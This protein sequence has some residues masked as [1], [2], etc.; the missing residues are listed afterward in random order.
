MA[1]QGNTA[2]ATPD[3]G[4]I[5][6]AQLYIDSLTE[7]KKE[8]QLKLDEANAGY[9][10]AVGEYEQAK[11]RKDL[12][13]NYLENI[14]D[15]HESAA[16]VHRDLEIMKAQAQKVCTNIECLRDALY[17]YVSDVRIA[18][19]KLEELR[20]MLRHLM[21]RIACL[22]DPDLTPETSIMKC[23]ND[24]KAKIDEA[25]AAVLDSIYPVL[26]IVRAN[27]ELLR[28]ICNDQGGNYGLLFVLDQDIE[29]L[30]DAVRCGP[31]I[32]DG[33]TPNT[34]EPVGDCE[35]TQE[36]PNC[37]IE[38]KPCVFTKDDNCVSEYQTELQLKHDNACVLVEEKECARNYYSNCK[39]LARAQFDAICAA[40]EAAQA[41]KVC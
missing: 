30:K 5:S 29:L 31:T 4:V 25:F 20:S 2:T 13:E 9:S 12:L 17:H 27:N 35:A 14:T 32:D 10:K 37:R 38:D 1:S 28:C 19:A 41:A 36:D 21:D 11:S 39:E 26:E 23:L 7:E 40:L 15:T 22:T 8:A 3:E 34:S 24:L 16:D 18:A 33:S 6:R